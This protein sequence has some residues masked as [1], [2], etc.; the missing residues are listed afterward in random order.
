[1]KQQ[2]RALL[3]SAVLAAGV[4][5]AGEAD[6]RPVSYPGGWTVMQMN[7]GDMSSLHVHYSPTVTDSIGFYGESNWDGDW[8]FAGVQY[9]RLAKRWNAPASQ[10][11][12][13]LKLGAGQATPFGSRGGGSEAAGFVGFAADW[14]T[15][16]WF[17]S[18]EARA[19]E[20]GFDR[21]FRQSARV[22]VAPYLGEAGDLHTWLMVEVENMPDADDK[23]TVTPLVRL[24]QGVQLVEI[25]YRPA[26]EEFLFNWVYRY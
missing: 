25:G 26:S 1:M 2:S 17:T 9:N 6:A 15:R 21:T 12:I 24:F 19:Y 20:L 8:R 7:N 16:R 22:G 10:G 13:Y 18:Y 3:A 5:S 4:A 23:V 11:N 14:E